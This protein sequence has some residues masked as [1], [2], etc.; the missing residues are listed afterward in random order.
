MTRILGWLSTALLLCVGASAGVTPGSISGSVTD[1]S[2]IAQMGAMVEMLAVGTGQRVQAYTD[3]VGHYT[4]SGLTPGN[5]D[6]KVSAPSFLP[7]VREE[8]ALA[9]GAAKVVNITLNTLFEAARIMPARKQ[10]SDDD[11][12]WKWTLRSTV[13]RPI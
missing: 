4:F 7:T 9:A 11:D 3:S 13:N 5:Y 12:T 8:V 1:S 6:I 2:G 10:G